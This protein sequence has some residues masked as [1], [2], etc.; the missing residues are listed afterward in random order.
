MFDDVS[1]YRKGKV[2]REI[3]KDGV[4]QR[5][6]VMDGVVVGM[7]SVGAYIYDPKEQKTE[8][9]SWAEWFPFKS[10]SGVRVIVYA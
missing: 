10:D 7:T 9:P 5:E 3:N 6:T 8:K 1:L 2:I 4:I